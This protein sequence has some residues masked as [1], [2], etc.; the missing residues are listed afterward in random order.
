MTKTK[1]FG[2][3]VFKWWPINMVFNR[4]YSIIKQNPNQDCGYVCNVDMDFSLEQSL[5]WVNTCL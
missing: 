5:T 2:P 3:A 1:K 4:V